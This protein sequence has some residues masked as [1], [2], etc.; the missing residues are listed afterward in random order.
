[1]DQSFEVD[2]RQTPDQARKREFRKGW[3][4]S[5]DLE[6]GYSDKTLKKLTWNNLGYRLGK[7]FGD[8]PDKM[9]EELYDWS[10]R[11]YQ[12]IGPVK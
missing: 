12:K 6:D 10:V 7:L 5:L 9:R 1:M 3:E 2:N 11:H 4:H 8:T